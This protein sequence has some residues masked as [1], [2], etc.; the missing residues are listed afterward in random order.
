M[1]YDLL[2]QAPETPLEERWVWRTDIHTADDGTEQRISTMAQPRR[3]WSG[4]H[5]FASMA[6]VRRHMATMYARFHAPFKL[7]LYHMAVKLKAAAIA[8]AQTLY[9]NTLRSDFRVGQLALIV[10]GDNHETFLIDAVHSDRVEAFAPL[11]RPYSAR[12][13]VCPVTAAYSAEAAGI[14]RR[15]VNGVAS[16]SFTYHEDGFLLPFIPDEQKVALSSFGGY[17]VLNRRGIG[18]SFEQALMTGVDITDNGAYPSFRS[19]WLMP[20]WAFPLTF[21]SSRGLNPAD[22]RWWRTFADYTRG[23][24]NPFFLP[25]W[26][27]DF[28]VVT[29]A[30]SGGTQITLAGTEYSQHYHPSTNLRRIFIRDEAGNMHFATVT[31]VAQVGGNDR[32]TFTPARPAGT[33]A[34]QTVGLLL[35]CRVADDTFLMSHDSLDTLV[36]LNLRTVD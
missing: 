21:L 23:S 31:A 24:T 32:L 18:T 19:R 26:R 4:Q 17:P 27:E 35:K 3:S 7:P 9:C 28:D 29:P 5:A 10:D 25:S 22:W 14:S 6:E 33:W 13:R 34:G 20:Q 2:L 11:S 16:A 8:G 15:P 1:A 12:A 30:T 36:T